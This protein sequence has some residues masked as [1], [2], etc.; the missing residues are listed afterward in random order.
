MDDDG[1]LWGVVEFV[2]ADAFTECAEGVDVV[3]VVD[4]LPVLDAKTRGTLADP[5][6]LF[7][8]PPAGLEKIYAKEA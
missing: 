2:E 4:P 5:S 6:L 3:V 8:R 7:P 1:V